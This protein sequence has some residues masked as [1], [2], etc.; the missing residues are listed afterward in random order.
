MISTKTIKLRI[1]EKCFPLKFKD[2]TI[3]N[4]KVK[5]QKYSVINYNRVFVYR[6]VLRTLFDRLEYHL[7]FLL[8][9]V[10]FYRLF[11]FY[12]CVLYNL[13]SVVSAENSNMNFDEY[14]E[15]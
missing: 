4:R 15:I 11:C 2:H 8:G 7:I 10:N 6:I 14:K 3:T 13:Q 12:F 5:S 9:L 1:R